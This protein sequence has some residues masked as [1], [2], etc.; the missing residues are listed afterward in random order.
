MEKNVE[1]VSKFLSNHSFVKRK[2]LN[3]FYL[4]F[5]FYMLKKENGKSI[6]KQR[7]KKKRRQGEVK[8]KKK[9]I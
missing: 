6:K 7:M 4:Q 5:I 1:C 3:T 8:R 9:E 2:I